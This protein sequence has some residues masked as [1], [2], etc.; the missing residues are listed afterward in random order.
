MYIGRYDIGEPNDRGVREWQKW[1]RQ[2]NN[3]S[4][5]P[6]SGRRQDDCV[7]LG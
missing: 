3:L 2:T 6:G 4:A 5:V 7:E 1:Q